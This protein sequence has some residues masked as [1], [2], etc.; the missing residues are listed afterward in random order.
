MRCQVERTLHQELQRLAVEA[1]Q[2]RETGTKVGEISERCRAR[3]DGSL[4][5]CFEK[6]ADRSV[7]SNSRHLQIELPF[8]GERR[9]SAGHEVDQFLIA[10]KR[11]YACTSCAASDSRCRIRKLAQQ[12]VT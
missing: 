7:T 3:A 9:S 2:M 6:L 8:P 10:H 4:Q 5:E 11:R 1:L 12:C